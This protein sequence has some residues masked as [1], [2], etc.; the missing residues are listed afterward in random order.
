M[1]VFGLVDVRLHDVH[2]GECDGGCRLH[3]SGADAAIWRTTATI[4][5]GQEVLWAYLDQVS[6]VH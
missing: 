2:R 1:L 5:F 4:A 6:A 3:W